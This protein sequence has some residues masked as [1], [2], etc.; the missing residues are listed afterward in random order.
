MPQNSFTPRFWR[1][2]ISNAFSVNM[3]EKPELVFIGKLTIED[4]KWLVEDAYRNNK[5]IVSIVGH[6]STAN[7]LSQILGIEVPVNRVDYRLTEN[8][9]LLVF[10]VPTRLPEGKV[11]TDEELRQISDKMNVYAVFI[12]TNV[13]KNIVDIVIGGLKRVFGISD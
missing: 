2:V 3:V 13:V 11:L 1:I 7:L 6:Q 12:A 9:V 4:A 5:P 8:D 10:T